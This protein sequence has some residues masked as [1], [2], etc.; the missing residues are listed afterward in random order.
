MAEVLK[1]RAYPLSVVGHV[2][3]V[4]WPCCAF[5][6]REPGPRM[7]G[8][9][10]PGRSP[11]LTARAARARA[12]RPGEAQV[13]RAGRR[14]AAQQKHNPLGWMFIFSDVMLLAL[15]QPDL[16]K[17][18]AAFGALAQPDATAQAPAPTVAQPIPET[19]AEGQ[20]QEGLRQSPPPLELPGGPG[21]LPNGALSRRGPGRRGS[22]REEVR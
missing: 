2:D 15:R 17:Y 7:L 14:R 11:P 22:W 19:P 18:R 20:P 3:A 9:L 5:W 8:R 4:P 10:R 12:G 1:D 6:C 21:G 13:S 16:V